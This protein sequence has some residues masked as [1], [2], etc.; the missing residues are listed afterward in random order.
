MARCEECGGKLIS[1]KRDVERQIDGTCVKV[2]GMQVNVC[3]SCPKVALEWW[4]WFADLD[5]TV[6]PRVK[7]GLADPV[8]WQDL[9]DDESVVSMLPPM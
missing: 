1:A 5:R 2:L 7:R 8:G 4:I 9:V 3:S 6:S